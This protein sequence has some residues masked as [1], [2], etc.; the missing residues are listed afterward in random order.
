MDKTI[1]PRRDFEALETR[2]MA[3]AQLFSRGTWQAEVA[4]KL[5]VSRQTASRWYEAWQKSGR[6]GLKGTGRAG[7]KP[8]MEPSNKQKISQI[9]KFIL[10]NCHP[11]MKI[12]VQKEDNLKLTT[13]YPSPHTHT[14]DT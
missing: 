10:K 3:A 12:S 2:R 6:K 8:R 9:H 5:D 13:P 7:R 4:Q 14:Q 1:R 11:I